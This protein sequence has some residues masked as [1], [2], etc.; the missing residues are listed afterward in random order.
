MVRS[1]SVY[2]STIHQQSFWEP[3]EELD[4]HLT[5]E[6]IS[7]PGDMTWHASLQEA[8]GFL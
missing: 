7:A 1:L 5:N 4:H 2:G 8:N 3:T 6:A